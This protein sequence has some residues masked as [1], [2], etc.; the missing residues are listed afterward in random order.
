MGVWEKGGEYIW[1]MFYWVAVIYSYL[2]PS[3]CR[4]N[5]VRHNIWSKIDIR[6]AF[7]VK[8]YIISV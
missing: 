2:K 4:F 1:F 3:M 8:L 7:Y 6:S 5:T